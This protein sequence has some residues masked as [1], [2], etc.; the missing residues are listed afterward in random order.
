MTYLL[1]RVTRLVGCFV[2][3]LIFCNIVRANEVNSELP[4]Y[5]PVSGITGSLNSVG[6]DTLN[7]LMTL[8][9]Q[10]FKRYYPNVIIQ[11]EGKGSSTAPPAL[12]EGTAQIGLMSRDLK[13][14]E[15]ISFESRY[16]YK[17]F[18]VIVALDALALWV[19]KDNPID[20]IDFSQIDAI[21]SNTQRRGGKSV[22]RWGE[23]DLTGEWQS[24]KLSLYGRNSASGTYG[25]FKSVVLLNGDFRASVKQQPGSS[26]VVQSVGS[27]RY[28]IGY[29]GIGY[30]TSE[31]K[32]LDVSV[33]GVNYF[34]PTREN[35]IS[36]DYPLGRFLYVFVNRTPNR[37]LNRLTSE[38]I[39]FV[40]SQEGQQ[41]VQRDGYFKLPKFVVDDMLTKLE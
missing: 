14:T 2:F 39:R 31:V 5:E 33:D 34:A 32:A 36:G 22:E 6:S 3:S 30:Y 28:G 8:W 20:K 26:G 21:F 25:F 29:S 35:S 37:P 17:P 1:Q 11:I 4:Q 9:A 12:I 23:L 13:S 38:F 41:I 19:H 7:N 10:A 27:D 18:K 24:R 16:Q 15:I 40:L